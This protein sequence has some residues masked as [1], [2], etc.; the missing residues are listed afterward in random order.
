L[1]VILEKHPK[2]GIGLTFLA[3]ALNGVKGIYVKSVSSE[4]DA[5]RKGLLI[6]DC[7]LSING[8]F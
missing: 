7:L 4:G 2:F 5:R 8:Q 1:D 3:G 6:D